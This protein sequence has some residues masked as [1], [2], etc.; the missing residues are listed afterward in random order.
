MNITALFAFAVALFCGAL[1]F[2]VAW[3]ERRSI[4]HLSFVAGMALLAVESVFSGLS[5]EA[6]TLDDAIFWQQWKFL[7]M[8]LLPGVWLLFSLSYGRGN[9]REFLS[10]WLF[11]LAAVFLLPPSLEI[12]FNDKLIAAANQSRLGTSGYVLTLLFLVSLVLVLMNL[13]RTFRASVGT[14]RWRIKFM[15]IGLACCLPSAATRA[16]RRCCFMPLIHASRWWTAARCWWRA[17]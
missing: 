5:W 13:E 16:A 12:V 14:M 10:R 11:L 4:A 1:A 17:C 8:S 9:Y 7:A 3:N 2:S 15:I 6:A